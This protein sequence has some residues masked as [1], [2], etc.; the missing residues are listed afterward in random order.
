MVD[1]SLIGRTWAEW[2]ESVGGLGDDSAEEEYLAYRRT[3]AKETP[4]LMLE[5][6]VKSEVG[7]FRKPL[8]TLLTLYSA[9]GATRP[10]SSSAKSA[11]SPSKSV[12]SGHTYSNDIPTLKSTPG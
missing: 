8:R 6:D 11:T 1:R 7:I 10:N 3:V 12:T 5:A 2:E 4:L 9:A